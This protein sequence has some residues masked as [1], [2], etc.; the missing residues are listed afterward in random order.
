MADNAKETAQQ[1]ADKPAGL[2][3]SADDASKHRKARGEEEPMSPGRSGLGRHIDIGGVADFGPVDTTRMS[4]QP[5]TRNI[6]ARV[7]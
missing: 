3:E 5:D 6:P 4:D 2:L 7:P 1:P